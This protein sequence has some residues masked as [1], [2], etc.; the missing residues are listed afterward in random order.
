MS[1][2]VG[3]I[4]F[5]G[6][7]CDRD[8]VWV[9]RQLLDCPTRL[10][11]HT[12]TTLHDCDLIV[13]PGGFSYGDYLRCGALAQFAPVMTAVKDHVA[14]GGHVLGICNGFQILVEVGLLPGA[15]IR[16]HNLHFICDQVQLEVVHVATPWTQFYQPGQVITVPI[17]HGEGSYVCDPDTLADLQANQQILFRYHLHNPNGSFD[18]IAGLCN[19]AQTVMGLMPHPERASDPQINRIP[20][21]GA[22]DGLP[23]WKG[24]VHA[25]TSRALAR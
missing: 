18:N 3:V 19:Q 4:V 21:Q 13:L 1:C 12:D 23:L 2:R 10:I 15:L 9:T 5:P 25:L 7:N 24:I 22:T 6:S 16:N 20:A 17:A 11:W 8:V 14:R